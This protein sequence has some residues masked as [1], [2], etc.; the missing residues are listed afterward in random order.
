MTLITTDGEDES[1][2]VFNAFKDEAF[3]AESLSISVSN[4]FIISRQYG[5]V[6]GKILLKSG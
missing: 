6:N 1:A 2:A 5:P 4:V 3:E